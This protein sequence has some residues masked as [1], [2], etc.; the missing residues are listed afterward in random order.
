MGIMRCQCSC[1]VV[2]T[3]SLWKSYGTHA[4]SVQRPLGDSAVTVQRQF[5]CFGPNDHL[6]SCN[7][8]KINVVPPID[9]PTICIQA[10]GLII[11]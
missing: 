5:G 6:K 10:T 3:D 11:F 9:A 2:S 4:G 7:F 1:C 8:C